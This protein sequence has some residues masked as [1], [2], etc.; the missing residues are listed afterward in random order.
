MVLGVTGK[1]GL[2]ARARTGS[3]KRASTLPRPRGP[4]VRRNP[5]SVSGRPGWRQPHFDLR[6]KRLQMALPR[7]DADVAAAGKAASVGSQGRG[8]VLGGSGS[9]GTGLGS[10]I[11]SEPLCLTQPLPKAPAVT[12]FCH[13][14]PPAVRSHRT[15][16]GPALQ[17]PR[18]RPGGSLGPTTGNRVALPSDSLLFPRPAFRHVTVSHAE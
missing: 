16:V 12:E 11:R 6:D 4:H 18:E 8:R 7:G 17:S 1:P 3:P 2:L 5:C 13:L 15:W 9:A 14:L 10:G